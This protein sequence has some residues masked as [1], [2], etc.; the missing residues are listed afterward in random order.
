MEAF[1]L[2]V[3]KSANADVYGVSTKNEIYGTVVPNY[4]DG[5]LITEF[6]ATA[7]GDV[8]FALAG[9]EQLG[10]TSLII[11]FVSG[12]QETLTWDDASK[13]YNL[14]TPATTLYDYFK[15]RNY[16]ALEF[17]FTT[18][19]L[20]KPEKTTIVNNGKL[21]TDKGNTVTNP[22]KRRSRPKKDS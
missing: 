12:V 20:K 17:V 13:T 2:I 4:I 7:A 16:D 9:G 8:T 15:G 10:G 11:T 22:T 3:G 6:I 19:T 18:T 21:V 5:K 14:A 1:K